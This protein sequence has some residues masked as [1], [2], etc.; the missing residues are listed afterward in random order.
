[1]PLS[2]RSLLI[3]FAIILTACGCGPGRDP[4]GRQAISGSVTFQG[5]PLDPGTIQFIPA[6]PAKESGG[7][8]LIREGRYQIPR[9][10]GLA[11]GTY[12]VVITSPEPNNTD[13]PISPPGAPGIKMPPLA[14]ERIPP[15]FNRD[16]K[17]TVDVTEGGANSFDFNLD[18]TGKKP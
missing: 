3:A 14:L 6:D 8:S 1:M 2:N 5:K 9:E 13:L 4:H 17:V 12:R 18:E 10:Q 11:P 7:G 16:S 15:K